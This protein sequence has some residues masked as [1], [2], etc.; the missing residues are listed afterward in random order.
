MYNNYKW[1]GRLFINKWSLVMR[2]EAPSA[3]YWLTIIWAA[4]YWLFEMGGAVIPLIE[5]KELSSTVAYIVDGGGMSAWFPYTVA[6]GVGG[7]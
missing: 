1:V 3:Y 7:Y 5:I 6:D 2:Y 4:F